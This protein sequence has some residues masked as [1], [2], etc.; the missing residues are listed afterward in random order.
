MFSLHASGTGG[1]ITNEY[2]LDHLSS[3]NTFVG[4]RG[5]TYNTNPAWTIVSGETYEYA[6]VLGGFNSTA[7]AWDGVSATWD[8]GAFAFQK[9]G[10]AGNW[11]LMHVQPT[12]GAATVY[13]RWASYSTAITIDNLKNPDVDLSSFVAPLANDQFDG[14][15]GQTVESGGTYSGTEI[16]PSGETTWH[17]RTDECTGGA[18]NSVWDINTNKL[19]FDTGGTDCT[20]NADYRILYMD[21]G[22]SDVIAQVNAECDLGNPSW[23]GLMFRG[24]AETG[25]GE[26]HL[27]FSI[28]GDGA[29]CDPYLYDMIDGSFTELDS[30]TAGTM[31][32]GGRYNLLCVVEGNNQDCYINGV[33]WVAATSSFNNTATRVGFWHYDLNT[34]VTYN[35]FA[36]WV[37]GTGGEYNDLD[38]Y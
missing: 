15:N 37:R 34:G 38:N 3:T 27:M 26:N 22:E 10:E 12:G 21:V 2:E 32:G 35:N 28:H 31:T 29:N 17:K 24:S 19:E 7:W 14:T 6:V 36:V 30:D 18:G 9:T 11:E 23:S 1:F 16:F 8:Y 25:S 20:N 33:P 13:P 4:D 5:N